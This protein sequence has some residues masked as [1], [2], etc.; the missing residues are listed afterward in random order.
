MC[1]ARMYHPKWER[2]HHKHH[3]KRFWKN[4][5][6]NAFNYPPVN[7]EELDDKYEIKLYAAGYTK[8][9]F[10]ID[11]QDNTLIVS[12]K[13]QDDSGAERPWGRLEFKPGSFE[14]RFE[15]NEK[16]DKEG[17]SAKYQNGVL[18]VTLQKLSDFETA[19][20]NIEVK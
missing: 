3:A 11:L 14:R 6:A 1:S 4:R 13:K 19:R 7:I 8:A 15:L 20:Q 2:H 17:I 12:V 18:T 16:I 9:D 10:Q 5:F